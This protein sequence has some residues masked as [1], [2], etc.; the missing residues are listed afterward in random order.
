MHIRDTKQNWVGIYLLEFH[1]IVQWTWQILFQSLQTASI[2]AAATNYPLTTLDY[3]SG[4]SDVQISIV[5]QV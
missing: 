5:K 4:V 2:K 1:E 3:T